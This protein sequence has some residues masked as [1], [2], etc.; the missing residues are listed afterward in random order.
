MLIIELIKNLFRKPETVKYPYETEGLNFPERLRGHHVIDQGSCIG[1]RKCA[2][3]CPAYVI[4]MVPLTKEELEARTEKI[5]KKKV[6]PVIDLTACIFCGVCEDV[7]PTDCLNLTN[8]I[9]LP[10][11]NKEELEVGD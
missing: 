8:H 4:E 7:C 6:K 10:S 1:C 5:K 3:A 2:R 11:G 9:V